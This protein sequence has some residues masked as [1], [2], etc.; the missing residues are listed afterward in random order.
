[1]PMSILRCD[2]SL[3]DCLVWRHPENAPEFGS[4]IIVSQ[5]QQVALLASGELVAIL[6]PGAHTLETANIPGIKNFLQSG[7]DA[8]PFDIWF[9]NKTASTNFRW[10]T[11]TPVQVRDKQFGLLV[12]I[13]SYGN[14][15]LQVKDIQAFLLKLVGVSQTYS[16]SDLRD[17]LY[18]LVERET[19]DAIAELAVEADVFTLATELNEISETVQN[20]L[21]EKFL[22]YGL[23]LKDFFVQSISV[24]SNDPSF[25]QIKN[26]IAESAAIRMKARAVEQSEAGYRT[27]R[28]LDV[29]E[30]L[31]G[32]EGGSAAA[33]A[34]AGLG[35]GAGLNIGNQ[36][37]EMSKPSPN[38]NSTASL[39]DRLKALKDLLDVGAIMQEDYDQKKQSILQDL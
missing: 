20:N 22:S 29:L 37:T 35:L 16:V 28:S 12:P 9:F 3:D 32:N 34:G 15:E 27:E 4:Q 17:Y 39:V 36:F 7:V 31:A 19:K 21:S 1:M 6:D 11:K 24:L 13:G 26:A 8:L 18:P 5:S 2:V 30:K 33:F 14:Y 38:N 10:G 25:E 23:A